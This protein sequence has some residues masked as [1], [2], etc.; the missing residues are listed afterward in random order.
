MTFKKSLLAFALT[1]IACAPA[2]SVADDTEVF[3]GSGS[4]SGANRPNVLLVLDTSESMKHFDGYSES[5]LDRMKTAVRTMLN[6]DLEVNIGLM[7]YNGNNGGGAVIYPMSNTLEVLCDGGDCDAPAPLPQDA[8]LISRSF[9]DVEQRLNSGNTDGDGNIL[10]IGGWGTDAQAV[11]LRYTDIEIPRGSTITDARLEFVA[12]RNDTNGANF[13]ILVENSND[14]N[15][16][17]EA[18]SVVTDRTYYNDDGVDWTPGNWDQGNRYDTA[19]ISSL[20]QKVVDRGDWCSGSAISFSI[21][22]TGRRD[23]Y[24]Y[25]NAVSNGLDYIPRLLITLDTS[26]AVSDTG[27]D[28]TTVSKRVSAGRDDAEQA[29]GNKTSLSGGELDVPQDNGKWQFTGMRFTNLAI[30]KGAVIESAHMTMQSYSRKTGW[31]SL[32]ILGEN[33]G[34]PGQYSDWWGPAQRTP[35]DSG[36]TWSNPPELNANET[37]RTPDIKTIVQ[38][39][40]NRSDWASGN[41]M[42]FMIK[43]TAGGG[44]RGFQSFER[45]STRAPVLHVTFS[46]GS[47]SGGGVTPTPSEPTET[48]ARE[49]MLAVIDNLAMAGGTPGVDSYYEAALYMLGENVDYGKQRGFETNP[50]R[51]ERH[52]VSHSRS[53]EGG[54]LIRNSGC[55][56]A[57]LQAS[58]CRNERI[59]GTPVDGEN[60]DSFNVPPKIRTLTDKPSCAASGNNACA[61]ELAAWLNTNDHGDPEG[62]QTIKTHTIAFNLDGAGKTYMETVATHGGGS[63]YEADSA[64]ELLSVLTNIT[65]SISAVDTTFTSPA[66]T[67]NQ[68]NRLTHRDDIYFAVFKPS[69]NPMWSGNVKRF[70]VGKVPGG[71]DEVLIRDRNDLPAINNATGFF[72]DNSKSFWPEKDDSGTAFATPDGNE[73]ERGGAANQLALRSGGR[74]R[75]VYTWPHNSSSSISSPV[76]LTLEANKLHEDNSAI[77]DAKLGIT[78]LESDAAAQTAYRKDLLKWARGVDV[79]DVDEDGLKTDIRRHMG[80]PLHTRPALINYAASSGPTTEENP[81]KSLV[82]VSTNE[83]YLHAIDTSDGSEQFAFVPN[84]LLGNLNTYY[85]NISGDTKPYGLDG[86]ISVWKDDTN[87]NNMVDNG[88]RALLF[89]GMRR[90]GKSYYAL[91]VSDPEKPK[92][93]WTIKGGAGGSTGFEKMGQS[94]SRL[95]PV[96]MFIEGASES[97][98]IFGGG[99]DENQ[100][101]VRGT[102]TQTADEMEY[103]FNASVRA[104]D[105]NRDNYVD[106]IYAAD[107]G[108][109]VWR[110]DVAQYHNS[111]VTNL[112]KGGVIGD[113][114]DTADSQ[115]RRFYNE[116]DVSLIEEG[117][118]RFLT[119]SLG[120]GWRAHPLDEVTEDRFYMLR[121]YDV[122]AA[123]ESGTYHKIEESDLIDVTSEVVPQTN[124]YGWMLDFSRSGEKVM[125]TSI[126]F[127]NQVIFSTYVPSEQPAV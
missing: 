55:T 38:K 110:F 63:S 127:D 52:R 85:K 27:C 41:A 57:N 26:T 94:W 123:P 59:D 126:T 21:R 82:F 102:R 93:A 2:L 13:E 51:Q 7:R 8:Y 117:G 84:E 20:V 28:V 95:T 119:V 104:I 114:S 91:D 108:G 71:S 72:A 43:G 37:F 34:N 5:R 30:P 101:L 42:A 46:G 113:F 56:D 75:R 31:V 40:V 3:F 99:Y 32:T 111:A 22:G 76:D 118:Q 45:S 49:E 62:V 77:S 109:Q 78:G 65:S 68:F 70:R 6:S 24:T 14:A 86:P 121:Q 100:D 103:G 124:N 33:H 74:D 58:A 1:T 23:A 105:I 96:K 90:G 10:T 112:I 48:T 9:D 25:D 98:L 89:V 64:D 44:R 15:P 60:D 107:A 73:V 47:S 120:S 39:I 87:G 115:Q 97:V 12:Y 88:E 29:K 35:I 80:D 19:D 16:L 36:I 53:Y 67:I 18:N 81:G 66:A 83:G 11:G 69:V 106:Q 116:P 92:L 122:Y 54:S 61:T 50:W 17:S 4:S 79:L 125:G